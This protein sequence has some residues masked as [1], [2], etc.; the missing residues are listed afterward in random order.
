M[1]KPVT[2]TRPPE[3]HQSAGARRQ[4]ALVLRPEPDCPDVIKALRWGL[5]GLLRKYHLRCVSLTEIPADRAPT[6]PTRG[7]NPVPDTRVIHTH[8]PA[9]SL[10]G[11]SG[12]VNGLQGPTPRPLSTKLAWKAPVAPPESLHEGISQAVERV[13]GL[14]PAQRRSV[15][16]AMTELSHNLHYIKLIMDLM[17]RAQVPSDEG[18]IL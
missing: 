17:P 15:I 2:T 10:Y 1:H 5:K 9:A 4:F 14:S 18:R 3:L 6:P 16:V 8:H 7:A 11:P 12:P 13:K